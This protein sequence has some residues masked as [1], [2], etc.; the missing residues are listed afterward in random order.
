MA[1]IVV[2]SDENFRTEVSIRSHTVIADEP[3][4]DGGTDEGATPMEILT[5]MIGACVA[6]TTRAYARRKQWAL[7][8]ITVEV[9]LERFKREDYPA[10]TGEAPYVHEVRERIQF[11]GSLTDEQRA[12]LMQIAAKC[13]IH[14][15]L[16]NPVFFVKEQVDQGLA[17]GEASPL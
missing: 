3:I 8:G 17:A 1:P 6:V 10:Y 5:G 9:E 2:R 11:E 14:I 16:E 7:E 4:Q 15:V 13:P 12:R